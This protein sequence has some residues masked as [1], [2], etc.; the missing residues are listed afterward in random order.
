[1]LNRLKVGSFEEEEYGP[2]Y[3][4]NPIIIPKRKYA[5]K[6]KRIKLPRRGE[7]WEIRI[8]TN[9]GRR[10]EIMLTTSKWVTG[11]Y[12]DNGRRTAYKTESFKKRFNYFLY[13]KNK[14][15]KSEFKQ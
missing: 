9:Q 8:G 11:H 12:L 15:V 5:V 4:F 3:K 10:I 1:M 7:V 14:G 6:N 2:S 13:I